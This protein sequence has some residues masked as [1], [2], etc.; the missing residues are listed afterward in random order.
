MTPESHKCHSAQVHP[1]RQVSSMA[2]WC[3]VYAQSQTSCFVIF[4]REHDCNVQALEA[5]LP[6]TT[7]QFMQLLAAHAAAGQQH[8]FATRQLLQLA[9]TCMVQPVPFCVLSASHT[10]CDTL[11]NCWAGVRQN[12]IACVG[13]VTTAGIDQKFM[14]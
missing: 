5:A 10:C 6:P 11:S 7:S 9:A 13:N 1:T 4:S 2:T 8:S 3:S 14:T 12:S